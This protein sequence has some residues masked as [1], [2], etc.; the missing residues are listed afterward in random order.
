[1]LPAHAASSP[2]HSFCAFL[3]N[4]GCLLLFFH[5]IA[6]SL[7]LLGSSDTLL[8]HRMPKS[9]AKG[10]FKEPE[11]LKVATALDPTATRPQVLTNAWKHLISGGASAGTYCFVSTHGG[12]PGCPFL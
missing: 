1:M 3:W 10:H 11:E 8:S 6:V 7:D 12:A 2:S 9:V 5:G 4:V